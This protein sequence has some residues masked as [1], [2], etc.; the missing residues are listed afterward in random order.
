MQKRHEVGVLGT[1]VALA[2]IRFWYWE[3]LLSHKPAHWLEMVGVMAGASLK[4][5][6]THFNT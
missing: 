6:G 4:R 2:T 5:V 1:S 3:V